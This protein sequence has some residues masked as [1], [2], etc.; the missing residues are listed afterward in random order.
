[1]AIRR[2]KLRPLLPSVFF[3]GFQSPFE[4]IQGGALGEGQ[5]GKMNQWSSRNDIT[6][7]VFLKAE[8]LGFRNMAY[9]KEARGMS[10]QAIVELF[11]LQDSVAEGVTKVQAD[12]QSAAARVVQAEREVKSALINYHGN[13]EGLKQ[14]QRFGDVLI[15]IFRPQEVVFSL[16]L[17]MTAY[18]H[19]IDTVADYN[20]AQFAMFHEL[21]YPAREIAFLRRPGD[22]LPVN[23]DRPDYLPPV[24]SGPPPA[25]R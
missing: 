17:L 5:G 4:L 13:V 20:T 10:S 22:V 11:D 1:V 24:G 12:L 8:G 16:Q 9:I 7:Q 21:G 19:Y 15:Q 25:T 2:E 18:E 6:P 23:T 14:T 3:N